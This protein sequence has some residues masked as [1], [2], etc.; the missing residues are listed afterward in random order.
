MGRAPSVEIAF[1][2]AAGVSW[3]RSADGVLIEIEQDAAGYYGLSLPR[4]WGTPREHPRAV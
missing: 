3:V 2:D 4:S 1:T